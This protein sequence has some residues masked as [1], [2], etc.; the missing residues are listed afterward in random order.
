MYLFLSRL[1]IVGWYVE[2]NYVV[3]QILSHLYKI[4][5]KYPLRGYILGVLTHTTAWD[6]LREVVELW[7][8]GFKIDYT[9]L[10]FTSA[11]AV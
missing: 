11:G 10:G 7:P 5:R 4:T 8:S 1:Y 9:H 3:T 6:R 2:L